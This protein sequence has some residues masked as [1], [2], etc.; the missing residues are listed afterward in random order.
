MVSEEQ[1]AKFAG[2][3]IK[4]A[5]KGE[6]DGAQTEFTE[7]GSALGK[8]TSEGIESQSGAARNS[9]TSLARSGK[10][11]VSSTSGEYTATGSQLGGN[12][13]S[14]LGSRS[15]SMRTE[16]TKVAN[17]GNEGA[18]STRGAYEQTGAYLT[19][20]LTSGFGSR[21]HAF[22]DEVRR[23]TSQANTTARNTLGVHSP[24]KVFA[25]IGEYTM[26]GFIVGMD[27]Y[28]SKIGQT[29]ADIGD[30]TVK[31]MNEAV[32]LI[33]T[34]SEEDIDS[35]PVITPVLDLSNIES[36]AGKIPGLLNTLDT[37]QLASQNGSL[38]GISEEN[39]QNTSNSLA[40]E[41]LK[42]RSDFDTLVDVLNGLS[43]VMDTGVVVGELAGPLDKA[44]GARNIQAGRGMY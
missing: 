15:G 29:T 17:A 31:S 8:R 23:V 6:L 30:E 7:S 12:A 22:M 9:G 16:G 25:E 36:E 38:I 26:E 1:K 21:V 4:D 44:L 20:G 2:R 5:A 10:E 33:A 24:S 41:M 40:A 32:G 42:L 11:G 27:S 34:I 3:D 39:K 14:G 43:I 18:R 13:A 28:R 35:S 37:Y 19:D